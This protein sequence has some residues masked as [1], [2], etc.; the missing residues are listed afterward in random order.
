MGK[1]R[2]AKLREQADAELAVVPA[3]I[4]PDRPRYDLAALIA[5]ITPDNCHAETLPDKPVGKERI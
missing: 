4:P 1:T 2:L 3:R 5:G